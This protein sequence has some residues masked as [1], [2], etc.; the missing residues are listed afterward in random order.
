MAAQPK[1]VTTF[2]V[3]M[4]HPE[5]HFYEIEMEVAPF[6]SKVASFDL[7]MPSW[8]PGSYLVRDYARNI[9]GLSVSF[10]HGRSVAARKVDKARWR[11][12]LPEKETSR[13]PFRVLYRVYAFELTVRTSHLDATHAFGNGASLFLYVEG[14]KEEP[15][16]LRFMLPPGWRS[17]VALRADG[18]GFAARDYDE[19]VDSPFECGTHRV[20]DFAVDGV[21][22]RLAVWG[23]GN[24]DLP[25]LAADLERIVRQEASLFGCLPYERYLFIVHLAEGAG[26]GL[27]HRASQSVG[28]SPWRF[29]PEKSYRELLSL[30]CHELFHA[31]NVKRIHPAILGPFDYTRE[32]HTRDLWAMEGLTSYYEW[33]FLLRASLVTPKQAFEV[34]AKEIQGHRDAP[35][36]RVQSAEEASFDAWIRAYRPDENSPNVSESYYRRGMLVALA[37]DLS[38]RRA[39]G[40]RSSLDDVVVKM[41]NDW[42]KSGRGYPEGEWERAARSTGWVPGDF[43]ER[44][45]RGTKSPEFEGLLPAVGVVLSETPEKDEDVPYVPAPG[46]IATP[47]EEAVREKAAFGWKTKVENGRVT[48]V[49]VYEGRAA[50]AAGISA[51]DEVVAAGG[52]RADEEQL[53]RIERDL[54]PGTVVEIHVF[55]LGRLLMVPVPLG[56]RRAFTYEIRTDPKATPAERSAFA[57]WAGQRFPD[58]P[59]ASGRPEKLE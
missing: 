34:F 27:E 52:I 24:E 40:G 2:T 43:F 22:H 38:I 47:V 26:G 30:F 1:P 51:G 46:P 15:H 36:A 35:G 7:V 55:R 3:A 50:Y 17:D 37:M 45:V 32:V 18:A 53:R 49:E 58:P 42:G 25:R 16:S 33:I 44:N 14:R 6:P 4:P 11:V 56:S 59:L 57:S 20:L 10:S 48:V 8:T 54:S 12:T 31:W 19:L 13:G 29:R 28:A 21:P 41:W 23:S 5:M 39:T 9:R